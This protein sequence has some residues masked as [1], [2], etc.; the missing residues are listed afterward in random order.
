[1]DRNCQVEL[2]SAAKGMKQELE[3]EGERERERGGG[4]DITL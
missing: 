3:K 2:V 1:M 4:R